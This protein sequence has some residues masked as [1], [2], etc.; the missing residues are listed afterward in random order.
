MRN[1]TFGLASVVL[2]F[3]LV[4][5]YLEI[6]VMLVSKK[7]WDDV[8]FK[9]VS[10]TIIVVSGLFVIVA[11]YSDEQLAPMIGLLGTTLGYILGAQSKSGSIADRNS[12]N[13]STL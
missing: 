10:V 11:G 9:L 13:E 5:V 3:G 12:K 6:R 4:V 8:T 1:F 2:V 7:Y